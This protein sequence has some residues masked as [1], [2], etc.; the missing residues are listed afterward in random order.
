MSVNL[1]DVV[2]GIVL[3]AFTALSLLRGVV[4]ELLVL[5]G[6][7]V[8]FLVATRYA[9]ALAVQLNPLLQDQGAAQL[10]A[11]VLL[12]VAGYLV[13]VFLAGFGDLFRRTREGCLSHLAGGVLGFA[14]GV[15]I[16]LAL[17]WAVMAYIPAFQDEMAGSFIG[18]LLGRLMA[19]LVH[20]GIL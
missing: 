15:T 20:A 1:F 5:L 11:F 4:R 13:G 14:K 2:F 9:E 19:Y 17:Y 18:G 8:G 12:M 6:L 3:L 16:S 10:L 7:A